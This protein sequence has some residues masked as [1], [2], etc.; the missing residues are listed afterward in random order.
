VKDQPG[1]EINLGFINSPSQFMNT[2]TRRGW[3]RRLA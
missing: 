3:C 2:C 1:L